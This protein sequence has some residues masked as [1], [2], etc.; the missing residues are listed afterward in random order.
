MAKDPK[1]PTAIMNVMLDVIGTDADNGTIVIY[2]GDKPASGDDDL[3]GQT[4]LCIFTL[5]AD[6]FL[7]TASKILTANP[8]DAALCIVGG[9]PSWFRMY[10][11]GGQPII[12]GTAGVGTDF[13]CQLLNDV[14]VLGQLQQIVRC[15]FTGTD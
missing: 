1:I 6:A 3:S 2:D 11:T 5:P 14:M 13:D 10:K 9:Y 8:V 7:A 12:D 15:S 4:A